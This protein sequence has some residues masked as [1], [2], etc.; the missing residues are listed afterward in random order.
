M[1][2]LILL[3][4]PFIQCNYII[5]KSQDSQTV[6]RRG[7]QK[8][9]SW[10]IIPITS[11]MTNKTYIIHT[12]IHNMYT[13]N[14][15]IYEVIIKNISDIPT[16]YIKNYKLWTYIFRPP[17]TISIYILCAST[18]PPIHICNP[19]PLVIFGRIAAS[20]VYCCVCMTVILFTLLDA[21]SANASH[22]WR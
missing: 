11:P 13:H 4:K 8:N 16:D 6:S 14:R 2:A 18:K 20:L 9:Q 21:H 1:G 7:V 10:P 5:C 3:C 19:P 17:S 12:Y 22:E 15:S